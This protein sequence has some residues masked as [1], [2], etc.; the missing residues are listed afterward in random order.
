MPFRREA[1]SS[2]AFTFKTPPFKEGDVI[3]IDSVS[4]HNSESG[5]FKAHV[6]I[7]RGN[8]NYYYETIFAE[9]DKR[10]YPTSVS[11]TINSNDR[12]VLKFEEHADEDVINILICAHIEVYE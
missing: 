9:E 4:V 1:T 2:S 8:T 12:I 10:Y 11:V 3:V 5:D 6:G 7:C